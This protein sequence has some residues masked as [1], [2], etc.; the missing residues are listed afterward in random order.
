MSEVLTEA[1]TTNQETL[2]QFLTRTE[3]E[4]AHLP[5]P[6]GR[7]TYRNHPEK[8]A[9][10]A[11]LNQLH[12]DLR[13]ARQQL[14]DHDE[15]R[16]ESG[17][18]RSP[19][20][21]AWDATTGGTAAGVDPA[22]D[23]AERA[24]LVER[25]ATLEAAIR[26]GGQIETQYIDGA[27]PLAIRASRECCEA[28][29]PEYRK[30]MKSVRDSVAKLATAMRAAEDLLADLERNGTTI[31]APLEQINGPIGTVSGDGNAIDSWL[32]DLDQ[33]L[34]QSAS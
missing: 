1:P 7:M 31:V 11:R 30:L 14:T 25:I 28:A 17:T 2:E 16:I 27:A 20:A 34:A 29:G 12:T 23:R 5:R 9:H 24:K 15:A 18:R 33:Y 19:G 26:H 3:A 21:A 8:L 22:T 6:S 10:D 13:T 32:A 4:R